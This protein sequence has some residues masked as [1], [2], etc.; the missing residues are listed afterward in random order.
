LE[1]KHNITRDQHFQE[2]ECQFTFSK[3]WEVIQYDAHD[4]YKTVSGKSFSGV[5]FAGIFRDT[6]YL[7]EVK[8]YYQY[9]QTGEIEEL[10][11]FCVEM[12]EKFL[13]TIDLIRIIQKYH[14]RKWSYRLFYR[15]VKS[16]PNLY[17]TWWFWTRMYQIIEN[18][19]VEFVLLIDSLETRESI[20]LKTVELM[21]EEYNTDFDLQVLP[22][23]TSDIPD[24][25]IIHHIT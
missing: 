13:D 10:E 2:S 5:D 25:E 14:N 15:L 4:Y 17:H 8:N 19:K 16:Y 20:K 18:D 21:V 7:I 9:N 22:I 24:L 6:L 1:E 23:T 3:E 12:K 11:N